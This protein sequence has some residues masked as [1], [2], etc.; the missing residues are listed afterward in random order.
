MSNQTSKIK[1]ISNIFETRKEY[2]KSLKTIINPLT[3]S[4]VFRKKFSRKLKDD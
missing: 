4:S 1:P 2:L 3:L